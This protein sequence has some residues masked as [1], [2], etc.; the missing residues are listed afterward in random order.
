MKAE[1]THIEL[2]DRVYQNDQG[3]VNKM[4]FNWKRLQEKA[5]EGWRL[6]TMFPDPVGTCLLERSG[7]AETIR[8]EIFYSKKLIAKLEGEIAAIHLSIHKKWWQFWK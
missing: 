7:E 5:A 3:Q 1:Y 4:E 2:I 8:S 6:H